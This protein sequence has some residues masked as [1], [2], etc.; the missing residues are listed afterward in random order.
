MLMKDDDGEYGSVEP[1]KKFCDNFLADII[2]DKSRREGSSEADEDSPCVSD[3]GSGHLDKEKTNEDNHGD[4]QVDTDNPLSKKRRRQLRNRDAAVRSRERKKLYVRDLEIK[5]RYLE[6][7]CLRLGRLLQCCY[8]ENQALRLGLQSGSAFGAS[9]TKQESAVLLL[10]S[11]L[12]GSLLW[13][14]GIMCLFTLPTMPQS[15]LKR[16]PLEKVGKKN[17]GVA[18]GGAKSKM[19]GFLMVQSFVKGRRCKASRM[20]MKPNYLVL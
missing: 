6:G 10:E 14:L 1:N 12:L 18:L 16:V 17:P 15:I 9:I 13:F 5:S 20:K 2:V 3:D 7:E 19:F 8:A 11:L 4:G